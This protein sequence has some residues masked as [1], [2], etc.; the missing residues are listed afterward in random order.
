MNAPHLDL[1]LLSEK[2]HVCIV[3]TKQDGAHT[4]RMNMRDVV[5]LQ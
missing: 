1:L 3:L 2:R 5:S 4:L